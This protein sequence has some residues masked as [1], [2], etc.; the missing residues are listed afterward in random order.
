MMEY[1]TRAHF[2]LIESKVTQQA[3]RRL[4]ETKQLLIGNKYAHRRS[5]TQGNGTISLHPAAHDTG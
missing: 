3:R 5:N 2:P 4:N 1:L